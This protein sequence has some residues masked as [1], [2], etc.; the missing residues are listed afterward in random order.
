M[1]DKRTP[2]DIN[3]DKV[4]LA[5]ELNLDFTTLSISEKTNL[6]LFHGMTDEEM[7]MGPAVVPD[8]NSNC[9]GIHDIALLKRFMDGVRDGSEEE[10]MRGTDN[11]TL[12]ETASDILDPRTRRTVTHK[13]LKSAALAAHRR[14]ICRLYYFDAVLSVLKE[15]PESVLDDRART[16]AAWDSAYLFRGSEEAGRVRLSSLKYHLENNVY[17]EMDKRQWW[18]KAVLPILYG[19]ETFIILKTEK[20]KSEAIRIM[21]KGRLQQSSKELS[22]TEDG[23]EPGPAKKRK[24]ITYEDGDEEEEEEEEQEVD[25]NIELLF[26]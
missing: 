23:R 14:F 11:L 8:E 2:Y 6:V 18:F 19:L 13:K 12:T 7:E 1:A 24:L 17:H 22:S 16:V 20:D 9:F 4:R 15:S 3:A 25:D 26:T 10:K 5:R 21:E